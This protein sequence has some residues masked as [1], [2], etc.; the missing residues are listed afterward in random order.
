MLQAEGN[1]KLTQETV[2]DLERNKMEL[3]QVLQRKEKELGSLS[4]KIEDEQTLGNKLNQQIKELQSRLEE[5]DEDLESERVARARA[6]KARG[7]LSRELDEL[8][9]RLEET[10][11][12]TAAQG[13]DSMCSHGVTRVLSQC[14][15]R[16]PSHIN[17]AR[18][19][20]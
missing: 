7:Q 6:D 16:A 11:G 14:N 19:T 5:L 1:L 15:A 3:S 2:A 20:P 13:R 10:G 17:N 8:N 12:H 18:I 4:G 9:E